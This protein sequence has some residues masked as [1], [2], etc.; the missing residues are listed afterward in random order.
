MELIGI[1]D[2]K[3]IVWVCLDLG[4]NFVCIIYIESYFSYSD[5]HWILKSNG[6]NGKIILYNWE[7]KVILRI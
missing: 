6:A 4:E 5:I 7:F 3:I 2:W 1:N